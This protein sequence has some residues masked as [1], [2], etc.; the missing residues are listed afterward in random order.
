MATIHVRDETYRRLVQRAADQKTTVDA[1]VQPVLDSFAAPAS[2]PD[3]RRKSLGAWM[4]LVQKRSHRY[5]IGFQVDDSRE[6]IY[7]GRGE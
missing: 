3:E 7:A 2:S 1:L 6:S 5:P 4:A